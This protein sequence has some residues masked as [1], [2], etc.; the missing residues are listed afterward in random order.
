MVENLVYSWYER[1]QI[2]YSDLYMRLYVSFNAWYRKAT[3][4]SFDRE[5]LVRLKKRFVIWDDYLKDEVMQDLRPIHLEITGDID[6]WQGLI[7]YWYRVRCQ[8]FHGSLG[9]NDETIRRAYESLNV[10]M[11]EI[12]E[13]MRSSFTDDDYRRLREI[14][15]LLETPHPK[16]DYLED[17]QLKLHQK[18]LNAPHMWNVDMMRVRKE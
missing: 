3:G 15:V 18:Y 2:D 10:F 6:D 14:E 9:S 7:E 17:A 13:R 1:A 8:L 11:S 4:S 5:G 12:V 16:L